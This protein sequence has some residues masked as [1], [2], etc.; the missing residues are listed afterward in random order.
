MN[1]DIHTLIIS[2]IISSILGGGLGSYIMRLIMKNE[3][4]EALKDDLVKIDD[5]IK[6]IEKHYVTCA[7]C[8]AKHD[9]VNTTLADMNRKLDILLETALKNRGN[10]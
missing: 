4:K 9:S 8:D 7:V 2:T 10:E 3:A 1:Y 5:D 6:R